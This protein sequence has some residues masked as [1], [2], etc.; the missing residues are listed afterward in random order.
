MW[1][2]VAIILT[3]VLVLIFTACANR[4]QNQG[5][6]PNNNTGMA[7]GT[8]TDRGVLKNGTYEGKGDKWEFGDES[9]TVIVSEG[10]MSQVTLRRLDTTGQEVNYDEWT[11]E[12][13]GDQVRPNLKQFRQD[14]ANA[15]IQK[16]STAVDDIAGATVSSK[17]W[18]IA[19]DR[20]LEQA[21]I[22]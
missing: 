18:K 3:L 10:K 9:A 21:E 20:A 16:Q 11:G 2:R 17:N 22:K 15:I 8:G 6:V 14:L 4:N 12:K 1:K 7:T 19:V 5:A 13:V